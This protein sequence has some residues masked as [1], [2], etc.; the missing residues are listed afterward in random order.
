[1]FTPSATQTLTNGAV[2]SANA[3]TVKI[4]SDGGTVNATIGDGTAEGQILLIR[5]MSDVDK[6]KL[7]EVAPNFT[8]GIG[9]IISLT[10]DSAA[11]IEQ[12]RRDN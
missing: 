1:M 7:T 4:Q 8:M 6:V 5:G 12:Y 9:D 11:W 10:W 3:A 2:I